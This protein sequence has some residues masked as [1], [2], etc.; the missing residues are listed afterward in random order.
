MYI[1]DNISFGPQ[2]SYTHATNQ[3]MFNGMISRIR[4]ET[5]I[6]GL[7]L[8][9]VMVVSWKHHFPNGFSMIS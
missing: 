6:I 7:N 5:A 1:P 8:K 4:L 9:Y 3:N 2:Y